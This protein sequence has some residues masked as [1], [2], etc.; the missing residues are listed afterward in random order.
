MNALGFA[1]KIHKSINPSSLHPKIKMRK[2]PTKK[3]F[4]VWKV[5]VVIQP[6]LISKK[7]PDEHVTQLVI[8]LLVQE[9]QLSAHL[10]QALLVIS[11][12]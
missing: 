5:Q 11:T 8:T 9:S 4:A 10:T 3:K 6:L 1:L 12:K 2:F 7:N